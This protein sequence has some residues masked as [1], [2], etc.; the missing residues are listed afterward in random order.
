[1]TTIRALIAWSLRADKSAPGTEL[2]VRARLVAGH[3]PNTPHCGLFYFAEVMRWEVIRV[4]KGHSKERT[5]YVLQGCPEMTRI[6]E[7]DEYSLTIRSGS[8]PE[9]IRCRAGIAERSIVD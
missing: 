2:I 7:G 5:L 8:S 3:A 1:M 9:T 6:G 4:I